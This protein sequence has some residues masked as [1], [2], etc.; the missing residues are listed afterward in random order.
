MDGTRVLYRLTSSRT[1]AGGSRSW[2][3]T[4]GER[5]ARALM[6]VWGWSRQWGLGAKALF[7][8]EAPMKLKAFLQQSA[9]HLLKF[10]TMHA[11]KIVLMSFDTRTG[12][13]LH[14]RI[15]I[16]KYNAHFMYK[17]I[18]HDWQKNK[19][20]KNRNTKVKQFVQLMTLRSRPIAVINSHA[21]LP[22]LPDATCV[23]DSDSGRGQRLLKI[24]R[25]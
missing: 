6:G 11:N 9:Y 19:Q 3:G 10:C 14:F 25:G 21:Q 22:H 4:N 2:R 24:S 17:F 23:E 7:R 8:G 13:W 15:K 1:C 5:G 18:H 12:H 20:T 16:S